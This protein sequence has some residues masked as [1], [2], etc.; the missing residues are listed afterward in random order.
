MTGIKICGTGS[1]VPENIVSNED[2]VELVE[3]SDEWIRTRTG[4]ERRHIAGAETTWQM[5]AQAACEALRQ[6]NMDASEIDLLLVTTVTP[7]FS[8]PSTAC[9]IQ[10]KLGAK[11]A[12]AMDLNVACTGLVA[13]LD[14]ARRYLSTGGVRNVLIVCAETLSQKTDYTDRS[15][16]VLFGDGAG[17]CVVTAEEN[18]VFGSF[19]HSDSDGTRFLYARHRRVT[20]PFF[21][22]Q[23]AEVLEPFPVEKQEGIVMKGRDV[24]KFATKAM[25]EAVRRAC[26]RAGVQVKDI[27]LLIPHQ[28]NLRIIETAAENLG[29]DLQKV[30]VN[31]Q[32]YGNTSSATIPVALDE[33]IR[34]GKLSRGDLLCVVGFGAGLTYG[35]CVLKY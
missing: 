33:S 32:E 24:Y 23:Q 14:M 3:T 2:F 35:A 5:G 22:G 18:A 10:G 20:T 15:T 28:A 11:N 6:A 19:L 1:Y 34:A 29:I 7:D 4:I 25:P 31:I 16:C 13:A 30:Y 9:I 17:A 8:F 21:A 27:A 12:F 26:E